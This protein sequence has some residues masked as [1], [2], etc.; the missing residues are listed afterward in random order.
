MSNL[1]LCT[2]PTLLDRWF[3]RDLSEDFDRFWNLDYARSFSPSVEVTESDDHYEL[4]VEAPGMGKKDI[5]V[6]INDGV[7]RLSGDKQAERED[8]KRNYH[9]SER[10]YGRF[11]RAFRLPDHVNAG[12]ID[13]KYADG[14]LRLTIP[15]TE[16]AK[17]KAIEVKVE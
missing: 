8:K 6:E 2:R 4:A 15:K 7:L 13:A 3:G 17:P 9:F 16:E 10:S 5:H 1:T 12:K 11:E 14:V